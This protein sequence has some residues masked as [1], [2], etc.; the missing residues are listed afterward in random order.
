MGTEHRGQKNGV[1]FVVTSL[2]G[3]LLFFL[4]VCRGK[5]PVVLLIGAV[6]A[7]LGSKTQWVAAI[8]CLLLTGAWVGA[9]LF[10]IPVLLRYVEGEGIR[11][12]FWLASGGI[13]LLKA[14]GCQWPVMADPQIGGRVLHLGSTVFVT[15][16]VAGSLV[17]FI[18]DS[19]IV[20]AVAVLME[21]VMQPVFHLPGEAAVNI[22]SSFVSSASV[23]V[24]FTERYYVE[25]RYTCRQACAVVTSFSVVS[26]GYIGIIASL[27]GIGELYGELLA[28]SFV[29]VLFM[30]AVM[31]RI[32]PLSRIPACYL[33]GSE[34]ERDRRAGQE[35]DHTSRLVQAWEAGTACSAGFTKEV[36]LRKAARAVLFA[37][38]IVGV[39]IPTVMIVLVLVYH[40]PL[41][42]WLGRP[43]IPV[44]AL[45]GVPDAGAAAPSVLIGIVEVSLPSILIG[46]FAAPIQT[47]FFVALLSIVQIIFFSEAGNAIIGSKIPLGPVKLIGI[48]LVRTAVALPL[49]A[50]TMHILSWSL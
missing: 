3:I 48:F 2:I 18:T 30:A 38:K 43:L 4:P 1:R 36:F 46:S 26:V 7:F 25:G 28:A 15:I 11:C 13:V 49:V 23:G 6:E 29:L 17:P 19:G 21:P 41:F 14:M 20:E 31:V 27:C 12:L 50:L 39:M 5:T 33:D 35:A 8:S 9:K 47:R 42:A 44:L 37:Q 24:Y 45:L 10:K 40:T 34:G 22:L 16:A 32:P